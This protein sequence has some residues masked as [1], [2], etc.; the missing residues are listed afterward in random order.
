MEYESQKTPGR[1]PG[2]RAVCET[3][4]LTEAVW[5]VWTTTCQR[6]CL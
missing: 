4:G 1:S 2:S 3:A 5:F 6:R